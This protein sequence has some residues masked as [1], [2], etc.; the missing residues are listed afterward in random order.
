MS[1]EK[2]IFKRSKIL[3]G[4]TGLNILKNS[5]VAVF[6]LGG[7]GSAAV[8]ALARAGVGKLSIFDGDKINFSNI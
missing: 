3:I 5:H 1:E 7:V 2:D 8:E 4:Q 6:G